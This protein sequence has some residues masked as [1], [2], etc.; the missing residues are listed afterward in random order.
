MNQNKTI[1]YQVFPRLFGN[2]NAKLMKNGSRESNGVGKFSAFSSKAL[3]KIKELGVTHIWYTG[4]IEHATQTDYS[5]NGIGRDHSAIVKGKAG[6]PYAIKDYFDIDPDL[7]DKVENRKTE[8]D[9]L[10]QRTHKEGLKVIIDFVPNHVARQ[11]AS[12]SIPQFL[13]DLGQNEK[14]SKA[15]DINNN[16]YYFPGKVLSIHFDRQEQVEHIDYNEFPAK[17]TGNDCFN[18]SPGCNDWYE[19]VKLNYGI[20]YMNG[21]KRHFDPIPSTWFVMRDI[22]KFWAGKGVDG[23]R[24]DMAE[25]VPVEFWHWVIPQVKQVANVIFIAEVYNPNEYRNYINHGS[26]DYLYDKVGLYDTL[27]DVTCG[28]APA[29]NITS[30]WQAVDDIRRNMLNF[31]ENH[32][33]QRIASDFFAGNGFWGIP[34]LIVSAMINTNPFMI[35]SGQELGERG[36]DEEGFSGRDGRTTIFD[37][38]SVSSIRNWVNNFKFDGELLT[39]E[40]KKLRELYVKIL[41]IAKTEDVI[42]KGVLHDLMYANDMNPRFDNNKVYAF[43][44]KYENEVLLVAVNF[45]SS[46][47]NTFINIPGNAFTSLGIVDNKVAE[48][49][50]MLTGEKSVSTLTEYCPYQVTLPPHSGKLLKFKYNK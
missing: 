38:W 50:D 5:I 24:C 25:M 45:D 6:S 9:S 11:Y 17:A 2:T 16:F 10:V 47:K 41:N 39:D 27:R 29:K 18:T 44:R 32:D 3:K 23:F 19:T 20:D 37:Y 49:E 43:L 26:F 36:M 1:I 15:F 46:E 21:G 8:F 40:Q 48:L 30:C 4:V 14:T 34:S 31:M 12:D 28:H 22:L 42:S 33:E 13:K 7:A 35:Y